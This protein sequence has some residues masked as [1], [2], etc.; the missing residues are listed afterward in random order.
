MIDLGIWQPSHEIIEQSN[1]YEAMMD[2]GI[3]NYVGLYNFSTVE[4]EHFWDY[5][6][7]KLEIKFNHE[8][9]PILRSDGLQN[10]WFLAHNSI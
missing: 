1:L 7:Q 8:V 10:Q 6:V 4:R 3:N 5:V 2:L 9:S